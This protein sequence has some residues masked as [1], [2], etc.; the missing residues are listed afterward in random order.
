M[1]RDLRKE[2][3]QVTYG[4]AHKRNSDG[5]L[6]ASNELG[7]GSYSTLSNAWT[8]LLNI[9][10]A[11]ADETKSDEESGRINIPIG[12]KV[13]V[14]EHNEDGSVKDNATTKIYWLQGGHKYANMVEFKPD[15]A[16]STSVVEGDTKPVTSDAVY[17]AINNK[18]NS[19][20]NYKGYVDDMDEL[21]ALTDVKA[22]DT[23]LV[24]EE[25]E[26]YKAYNTISKGKFFLYTTASPNQKKEYILANNEKVQNVNCWYLKSDGTM[27]Y[28]S[29]E[30]TCYIGA[31]SAVPV[32]YFKEGNTYVHILDTGEEDT[33]S[34]VYGIAHKCI[35][36]G[37]YELSDYLASNQPDRIHNEE[38]YTI[39]WQSC[40]AAGI[41]PSA[42]AQALATK[43]DAL[44]FGDGIK[45]EGNVISVS[46]IGGSG[47]ASV[48]TTNKLI[49]VTGADGKTY[50]VNA[51]VLD[52]AKPVINGNND[53]FY[54]DSANVQ[55]PVTAADGTIYCSGS[56]TLT[57][58]NAYKKNY[59]EVANCIAND[60]GKSVTIKAMAEKYGAYS[61]IAEKTV[62]IY[63]K[64]QN[65]AIS[66]GGNDYA[67]SRA[68][69]IT[70]GTTGAD[71]YYTTDGTTPTTA[72]TKYTAAFNV[73]TN[74][75]VVKAIAVKTGWTLKGESAS[76]SIVIG[77]K[78]EALYGFSTKESLVES[79]LASLTAKTNLSSVKAGNKY[80]AT[81]GA[82]EVYMY[83]AFR[84]NLSGSTI[85]T[86]PKSG[87]FDF[88]LQKDGSTIKKTQVG[89]YYVYRSAGKISNATPNVEFQ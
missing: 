64:V 86:Y 36:T 23:Y 74:N 73:T 72:S 40:G 87:G 7:Y 58:D 60:N 10:G 14:E 42:L 51:N 67:S 57:A 46:S 28:G 68:V 35:F 32:L 49:K 63:R 3:R 17:K 52:I 79:D 54:T 85:T 61:E 70:C 48:D 59:V 20:Y 37:K 12:I 81:A 9:F 50:Y 15:M 78:A 76:D 65:P 71:I 13:A 41:T 26:L 31:L 53:S 45:K 55:I 21:A 27:G 33:G 19:L 56:G 2:I 62:T 82:T 11:D 47:N 88:P 89:D 39:A 44:V 6:S 24:A 16:V 80:S 22:E 1:G 77:K 69:T 66:V 38:V 18:V 25:G 4:L 30:V 83:F 75:T 34:S 43:Q 29:K 5:S 8:A 84:T